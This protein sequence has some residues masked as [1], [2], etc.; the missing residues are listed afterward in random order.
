MISAHPSRRSGAAVLAASLLTLTAAL[1][2]PLAAQEH[3]PPEGDHV[4]GDVEF[5]TSCAPAAQQEFQRGVAMLHSFWFGAARQAFQAAAAA[6]ADCAMAHWGMAMTLLG[7]PMARSAPS[8][9]NVAAGLEHARQAVRLAEDASPREQGYAAAAVLLYQ[10]ADRLDHFAR[11]ARYEDAMRALS[12]A[13]PDD[14]EA[15]IFHALAVVANAPPSDLTFARQLHGASI[16]EPIFERRPNHPGLAHY[17]IHA[18]DAPPIAE[19]GLDAARRYAGIA[20]SAPHALHM[21]SHIFTRLGYWE[22]SAETNARSAEA[23]ENPRGRY[24]PWDYMVYAWLQQGKDRAARQIVDEAVRLEREAIAA[25]PEGYTRSVIAYNLV[26]M[27]ARFALERDAWAEAMALEV[28]PGSGPFAEAVTVFARGIGHGREGHAAPAAAEAD[29]LDA[30]RAE[31]EAANDGYWSTVVGAQ[32]LAVRSW[33]AHAAGETDRALE[34]AREAA[35]LEETVEKHPVT[36]G[37]I[38]PAR[39]L[40]AEMLLLEGRAADA[41]VQAERTLEREPNRARTTAIA[42][43]AAE[44]AGEAERAAMYRAELEELMAHADGTRGEWQGVSP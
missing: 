30:L 2:P 15:A 23:E 44:A 35:E 24:H 1:A 20:P 16:L 40:Y 28:L 9:D 33:A 26:A 32:A 5:P 39:E 34:L 22:E 31:L 18:Y 37:P 29:R 7:N 38:L 21:P 42:A 43:R 25:N 17:I 27:P 3:A 8:A 36:P 6:D 14:D 11:M 4:L 19:Q 10:D 12:E 41:L 13:Y